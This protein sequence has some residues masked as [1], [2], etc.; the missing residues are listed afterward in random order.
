MQFEKEVDERMIY[1]IVS[2]KQLKK[3][4][5][6]KKIFSVSVFLVI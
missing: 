6:L 5:Y 3:N 1:C 4:L 2:Q